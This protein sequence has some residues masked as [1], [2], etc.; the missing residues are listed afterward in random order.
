M[1]K[2]KESMVKYSA[3]KLRNLSSDNHGEII[4]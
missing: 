3:G 2:E 4:L 1:V